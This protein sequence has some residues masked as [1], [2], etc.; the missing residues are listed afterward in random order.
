MSSA[1][2]VAIEQHTAPAF[3][4]LLPNPQLPMPSPTP[5]VD[6][7]KEPLLVLTTSNARD[8]PSSPD[9]SPEVERHVPFFSRPHRSLPE[10]PIYTLP[11]PDR[12]P[13]FVFRSEEP[14][15][16][17]GSS[18]RGSDIQ[19]DVPQRLSTPIY[20]PS[21][22][23]PR[24]YFVECP[25]T[26]VQPF[27][28]DHLERD[29][30]VKGVPRNYR[31]WGRTGRPKLEVEGLERANAKGDF[32]AMGLTYPHDSASE[33][34]GD[35]KEK[36]KKR[37]RKKK[38]TAKAQM[39]PIER[40]RRNVRKIGEAVAAPSAS[41]PPPPQRSPPKKPA[42]EKEKEK[43]PEEKK[44]EEK[45]PQPV[46]AIVP[47]KIELVD[48]DAQGE[49]DIDALGETDSEAEFDYAP[50]VV[51][52]RVQQA[53]PLPPS[54]PPRPVPAPASAPIPVVEQPK[55]KAPLEDNGPSEPTLAPP[56][57]KSRVSERLTQKRARDSLPAP[58][59]SNSEFA[60]VPKAAT[61]AAA[62]GS[63]TEE[64]SSSELSDS[65]FSAPP[66]PPAPRPT[67]RPPRRAAAASAPVPSA[68]APA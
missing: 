8:R 29:P 45:R 24:I 17:D 32:L 47:P 46:V 39:I 57:K 53:P 5:T 7:P 34:E 33:G 20:E 52:P 28:Y 63:S 66:S 23:P 54:S 60:P 16:D 51:F 67:A 14:T 43:K 13:R 64:R 21:T 38:L 15:A 48:E 11:P 68:F 56:P 27:S 31:A 59:P 2:E 6:P 49:M 36:E 1:T 18:F 35:E 4:T 12:A 41:A 44:V 10:D 40:P 9:S 42:L 61:L 55:R 26:F 58:G 65:S 37:K 3:T 22:L 30:L 19:E 50:P 25:I 62:D